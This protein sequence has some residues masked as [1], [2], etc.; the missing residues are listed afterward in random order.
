MRLSVALLS[1]VL[2]LSAC[3]FTHD[4][5]R[6]P[7]SVQALNDWRALM[8]QTDEC[9]SPPLIYTLAA[10][11]LDKNWQDCCWQHDFDYTYGWRYGISRAD[12]DNDLGACVEDSGH[13]VVASVMYGAVRAFG[14]GHYRTLDNPAWQP[15]ELVAP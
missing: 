8:Q 5:N 6:N 4:A 14:G 15:E 12:A 1:A 11:F 13:P 7:D 2:A 10:A 3:S 9:S